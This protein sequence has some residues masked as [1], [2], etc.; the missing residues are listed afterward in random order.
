MFTG[1]LSAESNLQS[2]LL[3]CSFERVFL[4]I[5]VMTKAEPE[6]G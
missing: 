1:K 3:T 5:R 2:Q 6:H 4:R